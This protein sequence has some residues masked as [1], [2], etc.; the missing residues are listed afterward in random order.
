MK[1]YFIPLL[2][3]SMALVGCDTKNNSSSEVKEYDRTS[4]SII[5]PTGAPA[6]AFY[7]YAGL[8]NFE[9]NQITN[10]DKLFCGC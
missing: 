1:K 6:L 9:T 2:I 10:F 4:L 7:N 3:A 8:S 5:T